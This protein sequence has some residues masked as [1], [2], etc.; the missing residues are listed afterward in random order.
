M[1][2]PYPACAL[3]SILIFWSKELL[4]LTCSNTETIGDDADQQGRNAQ[5][6]DFREDCATEYGSRSGYA[7]SA[8]L[9]RHVEFRQDA[10]AEIS[11]L[12]PFNVD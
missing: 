6:S 7:V 11:V 2:S 12:S 8:A 9:G 5:S 10:E 4:H 3:V 1:K